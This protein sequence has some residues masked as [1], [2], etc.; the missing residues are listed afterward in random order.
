[1]R[2]RERG[3]S[4]RAA[5]TLHIPKKDLLGTELWNVLTSFLPAEGLAAHYSSLY[6]VLIQ[7]MRFVV[8]AC[9]SFERLERR[10]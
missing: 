3:F 1:M 5:H 9:F 7:A 4:R 8:N 10:G 6:E 2:E